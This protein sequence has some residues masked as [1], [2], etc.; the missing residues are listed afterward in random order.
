MTR[1][2]PRCY[3]KFDGGEKFCPSDG[4]PLAD[5]DTGS[6]ASNVPTRQA[7][8]AQP[9]SD[10]HTLSGG[11]LDGRYEVVRRLG[12]G[13]MSYV[14]QGRDRESGEI[15]ALKILSPLLARE[16]V[17]AQRLRREAELAMRL[18][19]PHIC[20]ILRLGELENG[21]LYLVMPYL[22]G[23]LL[24]DRLERTG[25]LTVETGIEFLIQICAGLHQAHQMNI[26]HRDLKPENVM[27]VRNEED[28][29]QAVLLDFGLAKSVDVTGSSINLTATGM[30][31]G[32]PEFM[33]PEQ[34]RG[35]TL[36][37][38]SDI[39]ALGLLGC[40]MFTGQLPFQGR[41][42]RQIMVSRLE[43]PPRPV[44]EL[45]SDLSPVLETILLKAL[46]GDPDD[47]FQTTLEFGEALAE[48]V[49]ASNAPRLLA[50]LE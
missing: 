15:V 5:M 17:P 32:T 14:Y 50:L 9:Y 48:V 12:E 39:Y 33:S 46:A 49:D 3:A 35:S 4:A 28:Y 38:R 43:S 27:I 19:H 18:N 42:T 36:D 24:A 21:L 13:G 11:L 8:Q 1:R 2:C 34:V 29:E 16:T 45:K 26:I 20:S 47:R 10:R 44:R 25:P 7:P 41:T 23:E 30:I 6:V 40:E 31:P 22:S 37:R